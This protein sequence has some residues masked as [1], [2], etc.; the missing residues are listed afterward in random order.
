MLLLQSQV[1]S[2]GRLYNELD[3]G[4]KYRHWFRKLCTFYKIKKTAG[5]PQYHNS[6]PQTNYP[7]NTGVAE[8]VTTFYSRFDAFEYSLFQYTVLEWKKLDWNIQQ[9]K[10]MLSFRNSLLKIG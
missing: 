8:D 1:P 6:I 2:K 7:Y 10:N 3:P 5:V 9:S 4:S